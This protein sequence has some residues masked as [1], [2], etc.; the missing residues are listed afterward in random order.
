M[1]RRHLL[2]LALAAAIV[3]GLTRPAGSAGAPVVGKLT[4]FGQSCF[5]LETAAGTRVVMD[6]FGK[7]LGYE[8]PAGVRADLVTISH[9]HPDHNNV[10]F[11][12]GKP[13]VIRGLTADRKGWARVDE[14][15]RD[16]TVRSVGV[17]HDDKRGTARGLD[18]VFVF[19]V[20]GLRIAHLGDLGHTLDD[21]QLEAIGSVDVLLV[22]VGGTYTIDARQA[23]RVVDQLRPRLMVV[24]MHY[25]TGTITI[26]DLE[27]VEPFLE[28]KANVRREIGGSIALTPVKARPAVEIVVLPLR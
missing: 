26:K 12:T 22:P 28:G 1:R 16:L 3:V 13:R 17:Y 10:G 14:K 4:W 6:P 23:T 24:P 27:P 5:L 7:G 2:G 20:G 19:E 15:F 11:V 9:E 8:L 25:K 18:T 21:E